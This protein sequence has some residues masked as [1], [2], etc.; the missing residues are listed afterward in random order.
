VYPRKHLTRFIS[1][2]ECDTV[3]AEIKYKQLELSQMHQMMLKVLTYKI[4]LFYGS[5][6]NI[7]QHVFF[8][9]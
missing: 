3:Q 4:Q 1:I 7:P 2:D 8:Y 9:L 6:N 5:S